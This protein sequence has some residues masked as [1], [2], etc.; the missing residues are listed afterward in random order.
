MIPIRANPFN[1]MKKI[2]ESNT[3][4][5]MFGGMMIVQEIEIDPMFEAS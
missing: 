2:I 3:L 5:P 1:I 4:T